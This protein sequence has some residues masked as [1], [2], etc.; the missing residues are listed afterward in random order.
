MSLP[1][2]ES[3]AVS[4]GDHVV[5]FYARDADL[6]AG[7]GDYLIEAAREAAVSVIVATEA[8]RNAFVGHLES[9]GVDVAAAQ[10][11]GSLL[12]LDAAA[13]LQQFMRDGQI[14]RTAFFAEIGGVIRDA[15][16]TGRPVRAYGEMVALLWDAG[17]VLAAID[18]ETLWNE[19]SGE[20]P[21]SLYCAYHSESVARQEHTE[22]L[23]EVCRLHSAVVPTPVEVVEVTADFP[24]LAT[25]ATEARRLVADTVVRWEHDRLLVADAELV[26][27]ELAANAI[28]HARTPFRISVHRYGP[29]V[30]IAVHDR[31]DAALP[32]LVECDATSLSGRGM[33]LISAIARRW[34]VELTPGGK[35]VWAELRR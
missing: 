1:S 9:R 21:F 7:V 12:L 29:V 23:H 10:G 4:H 13:T 27:T 28:V 20:L 18:L 2:L 8:H 5:Q 31:A 15:G 19:L 25:A 14:D 16:R 22:A 34:G 33:H 11:Q 26:A 35:T 30:R 24:A 17:D 3:T 6:V 32:A